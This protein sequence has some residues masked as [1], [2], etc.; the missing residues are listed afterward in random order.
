MAALIGLIVRLATLRF[1]SGWKTY[2][3][4]LGLAGLSVY[5]LS[6]GEYSRAVETLLAALAAAGLRQAVAGGASPPS[7]TRAAAVT[8]AV[9]LAAG[10]AAAQEPPVGRIVSTPTAVS[11]AGVRAAADL[12]AA[13][14]VRNTGGSDGAGLCVFTS[15][16]MAAD[17]Q[18]VPALA[19]LQQYMTRF[20][21]GSYPEKTDSV[22][23]AFC[24]EQRVPVPAY[25]QHTGGDERVLDLAVKTGRMASVTYAGYDGFYRG[26]VAHMVDLV[27]LDAER[28]AIV[29]NNRPGQFVWMTRAEFL[30]RWR[31][32]TDGG[33]DTGMGGGWAVVLLAPPPPPYASTPRA[34]GHA[35]VGSPADAGGI[36]FGVDTGKLRQSKRSYT[37]SGRAVSEDQFAAALTDDSGRANVTTVGFAGGREFLDKLPAELRD[38][39]HVQSY[40]P[41]AW[42][43]KQFGLTAGVTVRKPAVARVGAEAGRLGTD[44]AGD[45]AAVEALVRQ[46]L[47]ITPPKPP[48]DDER[49]AAAVAA[50][51]AGKPVVL[52]VGVPAPGEYRDIYTFPAGFKVIPSGVYDCFLSNGSPVMVRRPDGVP[53]PQRLVP[54]NP[55]PLAFPTVPPFTFPGG[56][57]NGRC[58][59]R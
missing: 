50:V 53:M 11:P 45:A 23:A 33:R 59:G 13:R 42:Q 25:V 3:A 15:I 27:H 48:T 18:S 8:L 52:A 5:L 47:D 10:P 7:L 12:P 26:P 58:P 55:T 4:A 30:A 17:W 57:P 39:V 49:Y 35:I 41:S 21:G 44:R 31:G 36:T 1:G 28:A 22:I 51:K 20:P 43:A 56:C 29:D 24:R 2:A 9:L 34:T 6:T 19:G 16:Q 46:A 38:R 14:H 37:L 54:G 32:V 40:E